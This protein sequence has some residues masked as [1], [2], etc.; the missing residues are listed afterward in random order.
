MSIRATKWAMSILPVVD[1]P[2]TEVAVLLLLAYHHEDKTGMC[3]PGIDLL[4]ARCGA[5]ERRTR[6]AVKTLADWGIIKVKRGRGLV[7]NASN[8]Y[9]LFGK[10]KVPKN[11]TSKPAQKYQ[12]ESGIPVPVSKRQTG[13][14]DRGYTFEEEKTPTKLGII[15]GGRA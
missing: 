4:S 14:D 15:A 1:L 2:S 11:S 5:G 8:K 10:P 7:G 12:F 13:A 3:L 6:Q 9:T